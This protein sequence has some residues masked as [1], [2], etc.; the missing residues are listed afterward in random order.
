MEN[1]LRPPAATFACVGLRKHY[2]AE[3]DGRRWR[4]SVLRDLTLGVRAGRCT[5]IVGHGLGP[6]TVLRCMAGIVVP[7]SGALRWRDA[8]G[9]PAAPPSRALVSAG[10]RPYACHTV[11]DVLEQAVPAGRVQAEADARVAAAALHCALGDVL[12]ARAATLPAATVRLVAT[13]AALVAGAH[14]ILLDRREATDATDRPT[15]A[16]PRDV[17]AHPAAARLEGLVLRRLARSGR[18]IVVAGPAEC[19]AW[20]APSAII[21]LRAGRLQRRREPEPAR[22]VAEREPSPSVAGTR[23]G[24]GATPRG[25]AGPVATISGPL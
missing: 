17:A 23:A 24:D 19:C 7:E 14:W 5:A 2:E 11:R 16:C 4:H 18:T 15:A 25:D 1:E 12:A 13:A 20:L 6:V 21:T 10:W 3:M 22:R 8:A 9:R